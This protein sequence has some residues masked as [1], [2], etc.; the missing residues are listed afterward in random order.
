[1]IQYDSLLGHTD[2]HKTITSHGPELIFKKMKKVV[3]KKEIT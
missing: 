1:M 3:D 2:I